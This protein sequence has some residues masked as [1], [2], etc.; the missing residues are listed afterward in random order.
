[1]NNKSVQVAT[2]EVELKERLSRLE[3]KVDFLVT[4]MTNHLD[5]W[6][7]LSIKAETLSNRISI[8]ETENRLWW[9][10]T[11]PLIGV[12]SGMLSSIITLIVKNKSL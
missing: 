2:Y 6:D 11:V 10:L 3:S 12:G 4:S 7:K 1:M 5:R 9:K 8:V